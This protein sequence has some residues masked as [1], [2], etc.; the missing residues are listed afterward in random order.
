MNLAKLT[1]SFACVLALFFALLLKHEM[2]LFTALSEPELLF[3]FCLIAIIQIIVISRSGLSKAIWKFT[4]IA[5]VRRVIKVASFAFLLSLACSFITTRLLTVHRTVLILDWFFLVGLLLALRIMA[6]VQGEKVLFKTNEKLASERIL[7]VGAG[8]SGV[9]LVKDLLRDPS[10]GY[11][12][13][14]IDDDIMKINREVMGKPVLGG[15]HQI[16]DFIKE[17]EITRVF[18]AIPS[19]GSRLLEHI[20]ECSQ[21][22]DVDIRTLP[23]VTDIL[24][25]KSELS[26]LRKITPEDLLGRDEIFLEESSANSFFNNQVV[27]VTG[28]GGSIGS[29]L[30]RQVARFKP[31]ALVLFEQCEYNIYQIEMDLRSR[32]PELPVVTILGDVRSEKTVNEIFIKYKPSIVY[33]AAAYK[34]V[35]IVEKNP[36]EGVRTNVCGTR[37]VARASIDHGV[38]KFVLISTDKAVNPTNIMGASKRVA[39]IVVQ[40]LSETTFSTKFSV[41]RFGNVLGSSG[42]VIPLFKKQIEEGGPITLTHLDIER[43]FMSIPEATRLVLQASFMGKGGEIFVLD[44]GKPVKILDLARKMIKLAGL[45]EGRDV[46]I[47]VTGL[48]PGEK[49]FEEL[50]ADKEETLS[51]NLSMIRIAKT[52]F[53]RPDTMVYVDN[54]ISLRESDS[55]EIFRNVLQLIVPEYTPVITEGTTNPVIVNLV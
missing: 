21:D 35:P 55:I 7:I 39:E 15:I 8:V 29:E 28:A 40:S 51:T 42:S 22:A 49:L 54:L 26:Q 23:K 36:Y 48:R 3:S 4:S 25:N 30:C 46:E 1:D 9:N 5:D 38:D 16:D 19:A 14:F 50:L 24:S 33:H 45:K 17:F 27:L 34:H 6:R 2:A 31:F 13:G 18:V 10:S 12:V 32:Y 11:V 43:Y 41:V 52:R 47:K 20:V 44:M 37:V 53:N